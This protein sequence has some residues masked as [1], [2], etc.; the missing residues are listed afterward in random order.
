EHPSDLETGHPGHRVVEND[1]VRTKLERLLGGLVAVRRFTDDLEVRVRVDERT[2]PLAY[3][4]VV[5]GDED[6]LWH[7]GKSRFSPLQGHRTGGGRSMYLGCRES[8]QWCIV[9][10]S[11]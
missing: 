9:R 6:A 7:V 2:K 8:S 4:E 5:V 1:Q 3:G 11:A 10:P